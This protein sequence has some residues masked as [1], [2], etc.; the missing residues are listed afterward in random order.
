[1]CFGLAGGVPSLPLAPAP[2]LLPAATIALLL[3]VRI[4]P[5]A[6]AELEPGDAA[7][8]AVTAPTRC[9]DH[10]EAVAFGAEQPT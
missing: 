7:A 5:A 2:P 9:I 3:L 1:M 6:S 4:R 10:V 8:A